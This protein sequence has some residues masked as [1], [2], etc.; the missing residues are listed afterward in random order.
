MGF[1]DGSAD[2]ESAYNAG[3][4]GNE[5]SIPGLGRSPGG[6]RGSPLQYS[7]LR[8][9]MDRGAWWA[10]IQRVAKSPTLSN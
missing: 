9:P 6:G 5:A 8:D 4:A 1:L 7:F 3:D 10:P 2:K